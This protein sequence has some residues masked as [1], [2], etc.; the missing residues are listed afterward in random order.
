MNDRFDFFNR[1]VDAQSMEKFQFNGY[2][3]LILS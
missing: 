1:Y 3:N 2:F